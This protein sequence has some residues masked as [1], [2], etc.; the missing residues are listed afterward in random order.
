[1]VTIARPETEP[2]M[3]LPG[4]Y[5]YDPEI[6]A[7]EQERIFSRVWMCVGRADAIPAAG[8]YFLANVGYENVIVLR[9]RQG[10]LRAFLNVCRHRAARVCLEETSQLKGTMQCRYH[11]WTYS[12]DG[13]LVGAPNMKDDPGFDASTRGLAPVALQEWEGLIWL[14]LSDDPSPLSDQLGVFYTRYA[15]YHVGAL[16]AWRRI[17]YD[18]KANWKLVV[19]NFQECC[20]CAIAHPELSAQV[21]SFKAGYVSGYSGGGA[22]FGEDI[23]SLTTTGKT[24]RPS[25]RDITEEDRHTYYGTTLK[26]NLFLSLHP[27]YALTHIMTPLAPDRTLIVCDW[28]FDPQVMAQPGFDGTDGVDFWD[29]VNR[30]DWEI[31]EITQLGVRSKIYRDGGIFAPLEQHIRQFNDW[32]LEKLAA[33]EA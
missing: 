30:Q 9:D 2:V 29:L 13:T 3:T 4:R 25:F 20:H 1:M 23:E 16:R 10:T 14:N 32:V 24:A 22:R 17:V 7:Q 33:G 6:F 31:C 12:L 26:P 18:V 21:P 8:S 15:R 11:A 28:L 19:E 27:D 5:Y